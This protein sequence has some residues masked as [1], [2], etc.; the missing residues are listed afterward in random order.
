MG[1]EKP[2]YITEVEVSNI[3]KIALSTLRNHRFLNRGIPYVKF[4]RSVR[5][6]LSDVIEFMEGHKI[7]TNGV[8]SGCS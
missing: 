7:Q 5:Y 1:I 8:F 6:R 3:T 2:E 4:G